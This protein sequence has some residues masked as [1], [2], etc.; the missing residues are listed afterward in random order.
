MSRAVLTLNFSCLKSIGAIG[1]DVK[2]AG[3]G[4]SVRFIG[5]PYTMGGF[6]EPSGGGKT[7]RFHP[8]LSAYLV[9]DGIPAI[10]LVAYIGLSLHGARAW[11]VV[12]VLSAILAFVHIWIRSHSLVLSDTEIHYHTLLRTKGIALSDVKDFRVAAGLEGYWDR[13]RGGGLVRVVIRPR[14]GTRVDPLVINAK[15]FSPSDIGEL[16]SLL[17]ERCKVSSFAD[18]KVPL[19]ETRDAT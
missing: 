3:A 2:F 18:S 8:A 15:L 9:L 7:T 12:A 11:N 1:D 17:R 10:L 16:F 14:A 4:R 5:S 19:R 6:M 13:L